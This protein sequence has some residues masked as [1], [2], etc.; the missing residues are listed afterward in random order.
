M[1]KNLFAKELSVMENVIMETRRDQFF[2]FGR[3]KRTTR[4]CAM[5]SSPTAP[6]QRQV[7]VRA[8]CGNARARIPSLL[9]Q[10]HTAG[11]RKTS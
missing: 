8:E 1:L 9:R 5:F 3:K 4:V 10:K 11:R 7:F 2:I 6:E